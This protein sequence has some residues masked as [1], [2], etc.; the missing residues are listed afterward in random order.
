MTWLWQQG[1]RFTLTTSRFHHR[2]Q[3]F[4]RKPIETLLNFKGLSV[5][6]SIAYPLPSH[7]LKCQP[8]YFFHDP[9]TTGRVNHVLELGGCSTHS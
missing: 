3:G 2:L 5:R 8:L 4:I 6:P 7:R 1:I 9:P